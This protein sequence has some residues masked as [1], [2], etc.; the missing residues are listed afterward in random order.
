MNFE[1]FYIKGLT[2]ELAKLVVEKAV[3]AGANLHDNE[4]NLDNFFNCLGVD[5]DN[6]TLVDTEDSWEEGDNILLTL[7][8]LDE[9]L[10]LVPDTKCSNLRNVKIDLLKPDGSID[11]DLSVAFQKAVQDIVGSYSHSN[12]IKYTNKRFLYVGEEGQ[13]TYSNT[14]EWFDGDPRKQITFKPIIS[15][16]AEYVP[17]TPVNTRKTVSLPN[18]VKVYEDELE[19]LV[20]SATGLTKVED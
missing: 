14:K 10:G 13:L 3:M 16:E 19:L 2:K 18:G 17:E 7:D 11:E 12:G 9:H 1:P 4:E 15:W 6:D 20:S 5:Y 8:Q